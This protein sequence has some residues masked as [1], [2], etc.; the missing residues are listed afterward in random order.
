MLLFLSDS[1][2]DM[3]LGNIKILEHCSACGL[4]LVCPERSLELIKLLSHVP[5]HVRSWAMA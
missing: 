5:K 3:V 4:I 2:D 1:S